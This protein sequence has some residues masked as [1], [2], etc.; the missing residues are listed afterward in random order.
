MAS[1]ICSSCGTTIACAIIPKPIATAAMLVSSTGRRAVVRRSTSGSVVRSS[2]QPHT[3]STSDA[4]DDRAE[5][6]GGR[7][8]PSRCPWRRRRGRRPGRRRGRARRRTSNRPG[9][10]PARAARGVTRR[11]TTTAAS[12]GGHP[13]QR[14]PVAVLGDPGRQRQADRAADAEGRAHRR[15]RGAGHA[16]RRDLAHQAD[17]D[18]DEAHREALQRPADEHRGQRVGERADDRADEQQRRRCATSTRCL[19]NRSARR[20]AIGIAT[21]AAEQRDR[22][23]PRRRWRPRCSG[24]RGARSGSG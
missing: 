9:A 24:A 10:R 12:A 4:A 6:A 16:R 21:A 19:P 15:D 20:P 1:G 22:D 13:E 17:A 11:A 3:S 5:R 14:V 2:Y 18:R 7:P 23:D 8:S